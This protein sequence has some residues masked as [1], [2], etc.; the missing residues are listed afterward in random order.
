MLPLNLFRKMKIPCIIKRNMSFLFSKYFRITIIILIL[1]SLFFTYKLKHTFSNTI[2][3]PIK[4]INAIF[5]NAKSFNYIED[6]EKLSEVF[7]ANNNRLGWFVCT[8][9]WGDDVKGYGGPVPAIIGIDLSGTIKG[10][11]LLENTE[12]GSFIDHVIKQGLLL[13]WNGLDIKAALNQ[14]IDAITGATISSSAIIESINKRLSLLSEVSMNF[15]KKKLNNKDIVAFLVLFIAIAFFLFP[16]YPFFRKYRWVFLIINVCVLGFLC[17]YFLSLDLFSSWIQQGFLEAHVFLII[18]LIFTFLFGLRGKGN[19]YCSSVCPFGALQLLIGYKRK[20]INVSAKCAKILILLKNI[21]FTF[22][23]ISI[24]LGL[25]NAKWLSIFDPYIVFILKEN[26]P[27]GL[28]FFVLVLL[29]LSYFFRQPW[30]RFL[31]PIGTFMKY[32]TKSSSTPQLK[33]NNIQVLLRIVIIL[34]LVA[35]NVFLGGGLMKKQQDKPIE[36]VSAEE[37]KV[38]SKYRKA[39]HWRSV[40]DNKAQCELCPRRCL[41]SK[42]QTG[43]CKV[44]KNID[45]V[46][47]TLVYGQPVALH[48]DPIEKKPLM[49]VYPGTKSFSLATVGCNLRC[50]FCQNWEIAQASPERVTVDSV[51]PEKIVDMA[52]KSGSRTIAFTYTEPIVFFEYMLDIAKVAKQEGVD[53]VMHSAGFI[54]ER[55]LRQI[56]PYIKAANI[57]LKGF[58]Q[59]FYDQYSQGT[60]KEI[61]NT[62]EVL[63]EEGVWVEITNL[64]IPNANDDEDTIKAMCRWIKKHLGPNTPVHF[65]RFFPMHKL[66]NVAPTS[67]NTLLKAREIAYDSG[68]RFI[69]IGNVPNH[70]GEDTICPSCQK[71]VIKRRGYNVLENHIVDGQCKF[72]DYK[73]SGI[74]GE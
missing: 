46:L 42:G 23:I 26:T 50:K 21:V 62:L 60:V 13:K 71:V 69:Y 36:S 30:C 56:A 11:S 38:P 40:E 2:S 43:F 39:L 3:I 65:S 24:F 28:M 9:P 57:D 67:L 1:L 53:C 7:D 15:S 63:K 4:A 33:R 34:I 45:G 66:Q 73:I 35:I 52:K 22:I 20:P 16:N 25:F 58:D 19:L 70:D 10:I 55:P 8:S 51:S 48:A 5:P 12:T 17:G 49:H 18:V 37:S 14:D 27:F 72:C 6:K 68:L 59:S 74:W 47:Y 32:L 44:R 54:E 31:C 41:L 29:V 64:I 61:L